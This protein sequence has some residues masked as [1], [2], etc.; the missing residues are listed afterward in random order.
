MGI[1]FT[2]DLSDW[3]D[4]YNWRLVDLVEAAWAAI[5]RLGSSKDGHSSFVVCNDAVDAYILFLLLFL[6][7]YVL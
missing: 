2:H 3:E 7:S 1:T 5:S 6:R 4:H